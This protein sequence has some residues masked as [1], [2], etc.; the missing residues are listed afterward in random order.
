MEAPI[1]NLAGEKVALGPLRRDLMDTYTRWINDFSTVRNL[2]IRQEPITC[3][4]E[5]NWLEPALAG[6]SDGVTFTIY[7]K[8]GLRPIGTTS[9]DDINPLA[10][11]ATFGIL[12]GEADA[13]GKGNGTETTSLVT[14]YGFDCLGLHNIM[15]TV[16]EYNAAGIRAYT[17]AGYREFGRRHQ[18]RFAGGRLWDTIYMECL[19]PEHPA[20]RP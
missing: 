3:E 7:E 18:A 13:R 17:K 11:T 8:D 9:L 5:L 10:R 20:P 12:I 4:R 19:A 1:I 14:K 6:K 15:L 16:F 2:G